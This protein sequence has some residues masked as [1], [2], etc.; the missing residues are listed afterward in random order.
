[1]KKTTTF[2][3]TLTAVLLLGKCSDDASVS[4]E[5][6]Y[7]YSLY[8]I[9]DGITRTFLVNLPSTYYESDTSKFPVVIG[10]HGAGGSAA[11]FDRDYGMT[12]TADTEKFISVYPEGVRGTGVLG[13]R[14]WNAGECCQ[15]AMESNIDDVGFLRQMLDNLSQTYRVDAERVYATG[16]SNGGMMAYR[17]ACEMPDRIAAIGVVS[18]TMMTSCNPQKSM[19]I[20]HIHSILDTKIPFQGGIGLAD[21]YYPPV[22]SI[23]MTWAN[24]DKCDDETVTTKYDHYELK[25]WRSC[26][27]GASIQ[28]YLTD[29]GGHAWPG[30]GKPGYW[31]DEPSTAL[32]ANTLL[33]DFFKSN[34]TE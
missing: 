24:A 27:D 18:C 22:D 1:M 29:D 2:L 25:E 9:H 30:G 17:L 34:G 14:T 4:P 11:Q 16:I 7:R 21:Y 19:P 3:L 33:F 10:M 23:L 13:L 31:S 15:Y 8:L 20:L 32:D 5:L 12:E 6:V 28:R 26:E